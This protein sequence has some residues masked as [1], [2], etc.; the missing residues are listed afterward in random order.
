M[1]GRVADPEARFAVSGNQ[2][3][4]LTS[5]AALRVCREAAAQGLLVYRIEGGIWWE[6]RGCEMRLDAIWDSQVDP[7]VAAAVANTSNLRLAS[8]VAN[9]PK[10]C[11]TFVVSM[12]AIERKLGRLDG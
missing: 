11:D 3:V 9:D 10:S 4:F 2:T 7:P 1:S 5:D 8:L 6:G 12:I